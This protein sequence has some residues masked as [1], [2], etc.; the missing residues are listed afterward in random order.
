VKHMDGRYREYRKLY[1]A[2]K[3]IGFE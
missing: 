1:P 2:I 3:Q